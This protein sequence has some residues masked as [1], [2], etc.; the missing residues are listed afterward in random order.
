MK[1]QIEFKL[2]RKDKPPVLA[3]FNSI[4]E[5]EIFEK[6][7]EELIEAVKTKTLEQK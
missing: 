3:Y 5:L 6:W 7:I 1:A 2:T 4:E